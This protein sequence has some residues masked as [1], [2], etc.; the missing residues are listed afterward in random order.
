MGMTFFLGD[1][2]G[3]GSVAVTNDVLPALSSVAV[4][5]RVLRVVWLAG[6][7]DDDL[8]LDAFDQLVFDE[9]YDA[10]AI[11]ADES[12]AKSAS[13]TPPTNGF[14]GRGR[15]RSFASLRMT[16]GK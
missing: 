8:D 10:S 2:D 3:N 5:R 6:D 1:F 16:V 13:E 7:Y 14:V 12:I 9:Y 4:E 11:E 15:A